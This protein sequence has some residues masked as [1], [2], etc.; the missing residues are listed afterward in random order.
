MAVGLSGLKMVKG[1][2]QWS[3]AI[4]IILDTYSFAFLSFH[5]SLPLASHMCLPDLCAISTSG[6]IDLN[7]G[8]VL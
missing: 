8:K 2:S 3:T 5:L 6:M 1:L 7:F 4:R